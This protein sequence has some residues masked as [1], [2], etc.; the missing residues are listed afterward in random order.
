MVLLSQAIWSF[1]RLT[2]GFC[3]LWQILTICWNVWKVFSFIRD[4]KIIH[5]LINQENKQ[6]NP[7]CFSVSPSFHIS[8][9][10]KKSWN[11]RH[12]KKIRQGSES[13]G[14]PLNER[15]IFT[16]NDDDL[17][18][19]KIWVRNT[20]TFH[21]KLRESVSVVLKQMLSGCFQKQY[22]IFANNSHFPNSLSSLSINKGKYLFIYDITHNAGVH[23]DNKLKYY[24]EKVFYS[25][26]TLCQKANSIVYPWI[27][28]K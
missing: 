16:N 2:K 25:L 21:M 26:P 7:Y 9:E 28:A 5:Y 6:N 27:C 15:S 12:R 17:S 23:G 10:E 14:S 4:T 19:G 1:V 22:D 11:S 8:Q 20:N 13:G 18:D 24:I 3:K